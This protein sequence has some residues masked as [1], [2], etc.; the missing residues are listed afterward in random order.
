M[1]KNADRRV[2]LREA[3]ILAVITLIA[4]LVL[5]FVNELTKEPIRMQ[6]EKAVQAAC[7]AVFRGAGEAGT[8]FQKLD[9]M[10]GEEL[11]EELSANGVKIGT[12]YEALAE[13]GTCQGYVVQSTS[14]E[15]YGGNIVIYAGVTTQGVL[16]GISILEIS[17]TPGL[18]MQ[19]GKVLVPQFEK[20]AVGSF[21]YT[22]TGSRSESEI[23]AISG[24]T[25]TTNA[26]T[27]AVNGA[28][29]VAQ[30]LMGGR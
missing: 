26:V 25:I 18:G 5:G 16:N 2:M 8:A 15:G 30:D 17:E 6:K 1:Q 22:K 12:V 29:T 13:D 10:P 27:N 19:A 23:D 20:K 9:Y 11:A 3:G 7:M 28:L 24:A 21:T 14:T 4:G